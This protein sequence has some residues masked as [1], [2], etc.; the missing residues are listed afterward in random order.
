MLCNAFSKL[1]HGPWP[2]F[3]NSIALDEQQNATYADKKNT[4]QWSTIHIKNNTIDCYLFVN[5][6]NVLTITTHLGKY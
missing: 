4:N 5:N 6:T 1:S 2:Q 3:E